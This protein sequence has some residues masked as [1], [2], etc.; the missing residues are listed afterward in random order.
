[1]ELKEIKEPVRALFKI[2]ENSNTVR[3]S[4]GYYVS[5]EDFRDRNPTLVFMVLT[6]KTK[7][8]SKKRETT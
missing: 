1:M 7:P 3:E 6:N 8:A 2:K 4:H 5:Q